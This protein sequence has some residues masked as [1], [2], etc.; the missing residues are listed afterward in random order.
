M[1]S[2]HVPVQSPVT[3]RALVRVNTARLFQGGY[4]WYV[5]PLARMGDN[6]VCVFVTGLAASVHHRPGPRYLHDGLQA[7]LTEESQRYEG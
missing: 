5:T 1:H 7:E 3:Q 2:C 6:L 4:V